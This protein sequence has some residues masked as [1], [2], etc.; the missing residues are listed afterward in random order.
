[1]TLMLRYSVPKSVKPVVLDK[2]MFVNEVAPWRPPVYLAKRIGSVVP[3]WP[4]TTAYPLPVLL[5][6]FAVPAKIK[7]TA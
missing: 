3:D 6:V 2:I 4:R 7:A 1:M 5:L